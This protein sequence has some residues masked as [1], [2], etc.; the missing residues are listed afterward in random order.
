M[1]FLYLMN[2][3]LFYSITEFP[4][5]RT[6]YHCSFKNN[7]LKFHIEIKIFIYLECKRYFFFLTNLRIVTNSISLIKD[8]L[9][10]I[11]NY[12]L[13]INIKVTKSHFEIN[14][15]LNVNETPTSHLTNE[16]DFSNMLFY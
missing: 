16:I 1:L 9:H 3:I 10:S 5:Y 2:N 8:Y 13:Q 11:I 14:I 7:K 12:E 4:L 6:I 15:F